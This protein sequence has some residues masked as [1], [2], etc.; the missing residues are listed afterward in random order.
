M[1]SPGRSE[2][3]PRVRMKS[4][5][6][7]CVTTSTG[8]THTRTLS[9]SGQDEDTEAHKHS[10]RAHNPYMLCGRARGR[11]RA[12]ERKIA[13]K[14]EG[15]QGDAETESDGNREA[16]AERERSAETESDAEQQGWSVRA[17]TLG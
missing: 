11:L 1:P 2:T 4:G 13:G 8:C 9:L 15:G 14:R 12:S 10:L 16:E 6:V 17:G 7:A 3:P 5:R